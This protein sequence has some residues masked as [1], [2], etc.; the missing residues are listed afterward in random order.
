MPPTSGRGREKWVRPP[1]TF[2]FHARPAVRLKIEIS[3][4]TIADDNEKGYIINMRA[5][6]L[7]GAPSVTQGMNSISKPF[8]DGMPLR[9]I[10]EA[11]DT[12]VR[13]RGWYNPGSRRPQTPRNLATSLAIEC[14]ELL[15]CFQWTE[16]ADLTE[17]ADE[18]ADIVLYTAQLA[19]ILGLDLDSAVSRKLHVNG[20]RTWDGETPPA[21]V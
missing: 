3:L 4:A 20:G 17:V 7:G 10:V 6:A 13:G 19:G 21:A 5:E 18:L 12:F 9:A 1:L 2:F 8:T 14:A 16:S 15:E 11:M